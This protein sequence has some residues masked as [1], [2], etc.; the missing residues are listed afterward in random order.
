MV[1]SWLMIGVVACSKEYY[2][3]ESQTTK[4]LRGGHKPFESRVSLSFVSMPDRNNEFYD[5]LDQVASV[6]FLN[7][8]FKTLY[9]SP[10]TG[11]DHSNTV[12]IPIH[13]EAL[14]ETREIPNF[15]SNFPNLTCST[16]FLKRS[17]DD[18][19]D[20]RILQTLPGASSTSLE[21]TVTD[22]ESELSTEAIANLREVRSINLTV[23]E[24]E[25]FQLTLNYLTSFKP[26]TT[27]LETLNLKISPVMDTHNLVNT[28][29]ISCMFKRKFL[30]LSIGSIP[31]EI[32]GFSNCSSE[33][34][35]TLVLK[36]P[37]IHPSFI[38]SLKY[39]LFVKIR[40]DFQATIDFTDVMAQ[41][42]VLKNLK[43]LELDYNS[44]PEI[45]K[46]AINRKNFAKLT[47]FE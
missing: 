12:D 2:L 8:N 38:S 15:F 7:G 29:N 17:R 45:R 44:D 23:T 22:P 33:T 28:V 27:I 21:L 47:F 43:E 11:P 36:S 37:V 19:N 1:R 39:F 46:M 35:L 10:L 24:T 5:S 31:K 32:D 26:L 4:W 20:F 13:V 6:K 3:T 25:Y 30:N 40:A 34:S 41:I 14:R 42:V 9:Y 18:S 16:L